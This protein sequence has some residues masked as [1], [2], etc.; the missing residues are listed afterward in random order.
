MRCLHAFLLFSHFL[1][2][3]TAAGEAGDKLYHVIHDNFCEQGSY[4][5]L[6]YIRDLALCKIVSPAV[7]EAIGQSKW[8]N[9]IRSSSEAYR[10]IG[11]Y[12]KPSGGVVYY[13]SQNNPNSDYNKCGR[14]SR[15]C[16]CKLKVGCAP[17]TYNNL[18][19]ATCIACPAGFF[20]QS[21]NSNE[22]KECAIGSVQ[23]KGSIAIRQV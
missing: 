7:K 16:I 5:H 4:K 21:R 6:E 18:K 13:N 19:S 15:P 3:A 8:S 12:A 17:G 10:P 11:C 14:E 22:C 1:R 20:S 9:V 23:I 2:Q